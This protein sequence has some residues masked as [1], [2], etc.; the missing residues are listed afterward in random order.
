MASPRGAV[1]IDP[2]PFDATRLINGDLGAAAPGAKR[3]DGVIDASPRRR[4]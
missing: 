3:C 4:L 1:V 2:M